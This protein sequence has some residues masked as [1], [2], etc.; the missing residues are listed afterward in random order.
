MTPDDPQYPSYAPET[1]LDQ[2]IGRIAQAVFDYRA[3]FLFGAGMS[4]DCGV[5]SGAQLAREMLKSFFPSP[6]KTPTDSELAQLAH[7]YPLEAV[8]EALQR[9]PGKGREDLTTLVNGILATTAANPGDAHDIFLS[10]CFWDGQPRVKR[11]FTTNFDDLLQRVFGRKGEVIHKANF[12]KI[13]DAERDRRIPIVH[14][15]GVLG[16]KYQLTESD[17]FTSAYDPTHSLFRSAL[18]EADALVMV[19]YSMTDP[20]FRSLYMRYREEINARDPGTHSEDKTTY[21]V[22]PCRDAHAYA[23]GNKIWKARGAL[24]IPLTAK[25][26]FA[27][28]RLFMEDRAGR[29]MMASLKTKLA[30]ADDAAFVGSVA[31]IAATLCID[32]SDALGF[33]REVRTRSGSAK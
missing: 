8:A 26:F 24:W 16:S 12:A 11:V 25:E 15:H 22:G 4:V 32:Q 6:T 21:V 30:Y 5:A 1:E 2:A 29:L 27:K 9:R 31:R 20:D 28:L 33:L 3:E 10:I 17:V 18:A 23:L 14:L 19:G 13:R 7:D